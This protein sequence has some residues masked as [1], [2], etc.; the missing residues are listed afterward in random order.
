MP[1]SGVTEVSALLLLINNAAQAALSH[2][3]AYGVD[4]PSIYAFETHPLDSAGDISAL[5]TSI[6]MLEGACH[7]LCA[8][9]APPS[10]TLYK[11]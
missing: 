6:K 7:Q 8:T 9:L 11:V 10:H 5:K 3:A 4:V 1:S 2:Y